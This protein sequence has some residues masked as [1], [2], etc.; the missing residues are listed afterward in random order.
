LIGQAALGL[1]HR[2]VLAR[3]L[4]ATVGFEHIIDDAL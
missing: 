4:R 2:I 3:G 1:N